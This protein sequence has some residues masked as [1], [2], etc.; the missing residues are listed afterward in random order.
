LGIGTSSPISKLHVFKSSDNQLQ[1]QCDNTGL[2]TIDMGGTTTPAKGGI[3]FSDNIGAL[4]LR[5]NSTTQ[6][7]L[8]SSG[9][10][11]L[12]VTPSSWDTSAGTKALQVNQSSLV[13]FSSS[14]ELYAN[15]YFDGAAHRYISTGVA[16]TRFSQTQ[17]T[18]GNFRWFTAPS[19]TAGNTI[20]FTQA[21]TLTA[22]GNLGL[23]STSPVN[24]GSGYTYLTT[25]ATSGSGYLLRRAGNSVGLLDA[26]SA[27]FSV[28]AQGASGNL[29]LGT[30]N[31][32]RA[33][34]TS[35]GDLL[36]GTTSQLSSALFCVKRASAA[37]VA[38]FQ[39]GSD[40]GYGI[41]F[42]NVAGTSVGAIAWTGSATSY[43]T[44]SDYR[45]K[46]NQQTLTGSGAF[47]DALKPKT[48]AWK[49]DGSKG[50]GFIAHEVQEVSP[51]SVVGEK[52]G[53]QMQQMEYGSA[54]F[55]ANIIAELQSLRAR[56]AQ[57]EAK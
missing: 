8:D 31:T 19:G 15:A 5:T 9:N 11:G 43:N 51:S 35:G 40:A 17:G 34:I 42:L 12:G 26:S 33:R 36:V 37:N 21:M 44:S 53:E 10:L 27:N 4:F 24:F 2:V 57:L 52:D 13:S 45:L 47:I 3:R 49:S 28:L 32:E 41:N 25:D 56:V 6:A 54:E 14:S 46:D 20:S 18:S 7:T 30:N 39:N 48:W 22:E 50:V 55:I 38:A 29:I 16:A 1:L 23:G